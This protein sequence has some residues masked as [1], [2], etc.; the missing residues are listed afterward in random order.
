MNRKG[1]SQKAMEV[2]KRIVLTVAIGLLVLA[3][4]LGTTAYALA[5]DGK[6]GHCAEHMSMLRDAKPSSISDIDTPQHEVI[7]GY[8]D[9]DHD[10]CKVHTCPAVID[11]ALRMHVDIVH[12][13]LAQAGFESDLRHLSQAETPDRPPNT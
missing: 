4:G 11:F 13:D 8:A 2:L 12:F 9:G 10:E 6:S 1:P 3:T 5:M 7:S